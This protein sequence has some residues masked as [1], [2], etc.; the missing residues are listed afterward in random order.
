M[1]LKRV[2]LQVG[3]QKG[4]L[5]NILGLGSVPRKMHNGVKEPI[6]MEPD[7]VSKGGRIALKRAVDKTGLVAHTRSA[8]TA[9]RTPPVSSCCPPA[10][11]SN[12]RARDC[13]L[14][15]LLDPR[16]LDRL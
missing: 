3:L 10:G 5:H 6:L 11:L 2:E 4:F 1:P 14:G 13:Q 8:K 9:A 7:Q 15:L 16:R 12:P